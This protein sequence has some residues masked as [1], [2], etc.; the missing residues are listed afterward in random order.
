MHWASQMAP[1]VKNPLAN[2]GDRCG[3]DLWVGKIPWRRKCPPT[4]VFLPGESLEQRSLWVTVHRVAQSQ[5][6][7]K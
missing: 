6:R 4:P 7:P 5:T 2:A 1:V 3:L